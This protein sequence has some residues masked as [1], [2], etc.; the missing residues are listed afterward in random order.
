MNTWDKPASDDSIKKT[1]FALQTN[2]ITAYTVKNE[3]EARKKVLELI[4]QGKGVMEMTSVTL[5]A[6]GLNKALKDSGHPLV[7]E[8]LVELDREKHG[9]EM[10]MLGAAPEVAVGSVHA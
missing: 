10:Q 7:K 8:R 1:I 5:D 2:G 6:I 4:P 3:E 9:R